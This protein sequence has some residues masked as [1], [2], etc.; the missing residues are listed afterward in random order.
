MDGQTTII[1]IYMYDS[2]KIW[3]E[4]KFGGLAVCLPNCQ[5]KA[6]QNFVLAYNMTELPDLNPPIAII[7]PMAI[8]VPTTKI[9]SV[10][11]SGYNNYGST[12]T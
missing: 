10:K 11:I 12:M 7:T 3:W 8:W 9:N 4:I 2:Q 6:C 5:I 1:Y